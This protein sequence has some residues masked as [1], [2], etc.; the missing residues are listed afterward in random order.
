M[1]ALFLDAYD[2]RFCTGVFERLLPATRDRLDA[3]LR[4]KDA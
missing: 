3:L 1:Y 2:D 4:P